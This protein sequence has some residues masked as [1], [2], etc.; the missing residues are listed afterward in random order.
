MKI[1]WLLLIFTMQVHAAN[2]GHVK[3]GEQLF[4]SYCSGCHSL[5]YSSYPK[6]SMPTT[7]AKRWF[8]IV[9][10]DL[11][12]TGN[13]RGRKRLI[14]YL[15]GFYKDE[16]RPFG[17]NNKILINTQMPNVVAEF[18]EYDIEL[19]KN[20]SLKKHHQHKITLTPKLSHIPI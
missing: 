8:N 3:H 14:D 2:I 5:K 18:T 17:S 11:S 20:R 4:L 19:S 6:V 7:E 10:R 15:S 9:P 12:F 1:Q 16:T 13:Y